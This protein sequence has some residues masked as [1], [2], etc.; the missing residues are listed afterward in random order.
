MAKLWWSA[1][2]TDCDSDHVDGSGGFGWQCEAGQC[3][4]S[5][6]G[7]KSDRSGLTSSVEVS[8]ETYVSTAVRRWQ[9]RTEEFCS[10]VRG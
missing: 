9:W 7:H 6:P 5:E 10:G 8:R 4:P 1:A 2:V 3:A